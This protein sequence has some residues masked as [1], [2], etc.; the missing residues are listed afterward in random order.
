[1][2]AHHRAKK[3]V[4]TKTGKH[5]PSAS[6]AAKAAKCSASHLCNQLNGNLTNKTTFKYVQ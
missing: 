1:M 4:D 2:K 6:A 3:V 5:Y